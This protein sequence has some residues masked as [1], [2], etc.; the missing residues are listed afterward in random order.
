MIFGES[1]M[2][3]SKNNKWWKSDCI[4]DMIFL[5]QWNTIIEVGCY[6]EN[7]QEIETFFSE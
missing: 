4:P 6:N 3:R 5:N 1:M 2:N 7:Y